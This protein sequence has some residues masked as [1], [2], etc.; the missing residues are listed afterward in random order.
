MFSDRVRTRHLDVME[1]DRIRAEDDNDEEDAALQYMIEQSLLE[2]TKQRER[3]QD[4]TP[5]GTRRSDKDTKSVLVKLSLIFCLFL[6][7]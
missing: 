2:R 4:S 1:L 3:P 5:Q 7:H 6:H